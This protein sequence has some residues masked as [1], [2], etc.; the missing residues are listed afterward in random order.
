MIPGLKPKKGYKFGKYEIR[1]HMLYKGYVFLLSV[2]EGS[3][4]WSA[5][6]FDGDF[7]APL[8]QLARILH[9]AHDTQVDGLI[10]EAEQKE[11]R[12]YV[13]LTVDDQTKLLKP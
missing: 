2:H 3:A 1:K 5:H 12:E 9:A 6:K 13:E 10:L 7:S 8:E 4:Y 11:A